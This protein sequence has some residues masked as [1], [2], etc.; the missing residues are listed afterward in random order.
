M[1]QLGGTKQ[2]KTNLH[3]R[4]CGRRKPEAK[5]VGQKA[6]T[7]PSRGQDSNGWRAVLRQSPSQRENSDHPVS[8]FIGA[9]SDQTKRNGVPAFGATSAHV[10]ANPVKRSRCTRPHFDENH[11]TFVNRRSAKCSAANLP[12]SGSSPHTVGGRYVYGQLP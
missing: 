4:G 1:G 12:I 8:V 5:P 2:P 10:F 7:R 3:P 11:A 6:D 9:C